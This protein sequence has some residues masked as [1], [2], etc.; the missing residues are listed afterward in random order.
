MEIRGLAHASSGHWGGG[1]MTK[2]ALIL[3]GAPRI[4]RDGTPVTVDTRKAVALLAYLVV[5]RQPQRRD[6]LAD[7]LWPEYDQERA[8]ATLRRTLSALNAAIAGDWLLVSRETVGLNPHAPIWSDVETF[9]EHLSACPRPQQQPGQV[10]DECLSSLTEA[11]DLYVDH[12]MAGFTLRDSPDFDDWQ[13]LQ[14]EELQRELA[15]ALEALVAGHSAAGN[16]DTAI[17]LARRRL[18]LD[19]LHEPAHCALMELYSR[20]GRRAAALQQYRECVHVLDRE[21]GVAPLDSTTRLYEAI[22]EQRLPLTPGPGSDQ[23]HAAV[24]AQSSAVSPGRGSVA[25]HAPASAAA[26][27]PE[28]YPLRGRA[29]EWGALMRAYSTVGTDGRVAILDGEAGI[30]KTRLAEEFLAH[31]RMRGATVISGR[32]YEGEAQ[33]AFG[34]VGAALRGALA[35]PV[36]AGRL[37]AVPDVWLAEVARLAPELLHRGMKLPPP[38]EL[39]SPGAQGRFFEGVRSA[40]LDFC[41][42]PGGP[43]GILFIDDV[44]WADNASIELLT[45]LVRRMRDYPLLL[46]L[47]WRHDEAAQSRRL[48]LLL[49]DAQRS[50]A[51]TVIPLSRLALDDVRELARASGAAGGTPTEELTRR[52]HHETE[53]LPLFVVEYLA[54]LANG[55]LSSN[56]RN[57]VLPGGVRDLLSSRLSAVSETGW[58][59][60]TA[61]AA[62][63]RSFEFETVREVS[64]RS[65][66]ETVAA[67][68][69]LIAHGLVEEVAGR[70]GALTYDFRHDKTRALVY[71]DTS[72][73]RRRLLHR[74]IAESLLARSRGARDPGSLAGQI[75][76]HFAAA[77]N[78]A[79]AAAHYKLAGERARTLYA[80]AEALAHLKSALALGHPQEATLHEAIGDLHTLLGEYRAAL[81]SYEAAAALTD[82]DQCARL[83]CKLAGVYARRGEWELSESH[84][85]DALD[86]WGEDGPAGD[87]ARALADLSLIA[88]HRGRLDQAADLAR[89][90]LDLATEAGDARALAQAHNVLGMLANGQRQFDQ[91]LEHLVRSLSL[92]ERLDDATIRIAALNNLSLVHAARGDAQT[93]RALAET[94][95]QL[96]ATHGDR[97]RE[98]A[99]YNNLADLLR[100]SGDLEGAMAHLKTAVV[101]FAEIG[102]EAGTPQPEIWKLTEW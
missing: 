96:C 36:V 34:A 70:A 76:A 75:A 28:R 30:G 42:G 24:V 20:A 89:E 98:A 25:E 87:R 56:E 86:A 55:A 40:L 9:R 1:D 59:V 46:L 41:G 62:M 22:K 92:A 19:R 94:A 29:A 39:D 91:A 90:A 4:E 26:R 6:R 51:A 3:F 11:A 80:H 21:L 53:G 81:T 77:G 5:T 37:D 82:V 83:D 102:A 79:E 65:E 44:H 27:A 78:D 32:C 97:H 52:L 66:E 101:I 38:A 99:L 57:W 17:G 2:L 84:I 31:V 18:A 49:A 54:A 64:G 93:A 69:E 45:Y 12:F 50:E 47:S 13:F 60:L 71:D 43:P 63:G 85:V 8:R 23:P 14:R 100:A 67:L 73:A 74:R 48:R 15:G 61:A 72:L 88:R 35:Q 95:L 33:L 58:Q 16:F 10:S 7:L 68:E